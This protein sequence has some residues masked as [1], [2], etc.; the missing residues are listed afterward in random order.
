MDRTNADH[1]AAAKAALGN[2]HMSDRELGELLSEFSS[3]GRSFSPQVIQHARAENMSDEV[4]LAIGQL[5][6]Q[7]DVIHAG[8]V[9]T[10]ARAYR[11]KKPQIRDVMMS[12]AAK[13]LT[14]TPSKAAARS[15]LGGVAVAV[16]L[17]AGAPSP[18][19]AQAQQSGVNPESVSYVK[20]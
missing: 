5:L 20:L 6:Q 15:A 12:F 8:V 16:A 10:V 18:S 4:A 13:T 1:V 11:E 2:V 9:L 19:Q 14:A 17:T 7:R 3:D